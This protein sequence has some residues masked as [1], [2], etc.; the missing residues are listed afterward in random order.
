MTEKCKSLG[1]TS[2]RNEYGGIEAIDQFVRSQWKAKCSFTNCQVQVELPFFAFFLGDSY[3]NLEDF[4][5]L[6]FSFQCAYFV[7]FVDEKIYKF[8]TDR[9]W[10]NPLRLMTGV[11]EGLLKFFQISFCPSKWVLGTATDKSP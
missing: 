2:I 9:S 6:N 1:N 5:A 8:S 7:Q 3:T 11:L 4:L 10:E